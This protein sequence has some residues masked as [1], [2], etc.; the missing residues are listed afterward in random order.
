[1]S[2]EILI[3]AAKYVRELLD[4]DEQLIRIGRSNFERQ[5]FDL[6]YIGIDI[7]GPMTRYSRLENYDGENEIASY[8]GVW[9]GPLIIDFYGAGASMRAIE[10]SLLTHSQA[11]LELQQSLGVA[12]YSPSQIVDVRA[13]TGQQYGERMQITATAEISVDIDIET[14]R[15]DIAQVEI[16]DEAGIQYA[17]E[18]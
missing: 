11:A 17:G 3:R 4:Y 6:E 13:L 7:L 2:S 1:M 18:I 14:L 15:I 9:R 16:R 10:F 8:G 5:D 12:I